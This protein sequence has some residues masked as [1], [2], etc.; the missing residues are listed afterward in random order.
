MAAALARADPARLAGVPILT[1]E[2]V[3]D[4][5]G[6]DR[7]TWLS[8]NKK[9]VEKRVATKLPTVHYV[10]ARSALG[11]SNE[12]HE[13]ATE[14]PYFIVQM[15]EYP[16]MDLIYIKLKDNNTKNNKKT[17]TL[18][19]EGFSYGLPHWDSNIFKGLAFSDDDMKIERKCTGTAVWTLG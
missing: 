13:A 16:G 7:S 8:D 5:R 17:E 18:N 15:G 19:F 12:T 14:S 10:V 11:R 6:K 3:V 2:Y 4:L 9:G 1:R